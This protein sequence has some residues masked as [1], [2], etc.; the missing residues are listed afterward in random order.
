MQRV[1]RHAR[2]CSHVIKAWRQSSKAANPSSSQLALTDNGNC[3]ATVGIPPLISRKTAKTLNQARRQG[4]NVRAISDAA[5]VP[6]NPGCLPIQQATQSIHQGCDHTSRIWA[7]P[8]SQSCLYISQD[9]KNNVQSASESAG[10]PV[11]P[12]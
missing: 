7:A 2:E 10:V 1:S 4:K 3:P 12:G 11:N 6:A 5:G 8:G 9:G